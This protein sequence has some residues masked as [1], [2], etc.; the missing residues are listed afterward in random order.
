MDWKI[1]NEFSFEREK[2]NI[3]KIWWLK[4]DKVILG[5]ILFLILFGLFMNFTSSPPIARRIEVEQLF[6]FKKHLIFASISI[7]ILIFF[8]YLRVNHI[9]LIAP[10]LFVIIIITLILTLIFGNEIKGAKRWIS[11]FGFTIQPSE[12]AKVFF[13][14]FNAFLLDKFH[15]RKFYIKYGASG[16]S[17]MILVLLLILQPDFGMSFMMILLWSTQLFLYG[18]PWLAIFMILLCAIAGVISSYI[19]L[20]HVQDR[21]DRFFEIGNNYQVER[22]IDAYINGGF[23]GTGPGGGLVKKHIPDSHS[24]FIFSVIAEEFGIIIS[25]III[26]IFLYL[27][28]VVIKKNN[29]TKGY[30]S[31]L[32][33]SGLIIQFAA[34]III[35]IGVSLEMLPTKGIT[36]PFISYGGSSLIA[37]SISFGI[38]LAL[39]RKRYQTIIKDEELLLSDEQD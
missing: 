27:I 15:D 38:I 11:I 39:T 5:L 29:I 18:L 34:Q 13:I 31:Y 25:S 6:F 10:P 32:T 26:F 7:F 4:I 35:N 37:M 24:D 16:I 2:L 9:K 12:F 20:P 14:I 23:F 21:V 3:I 22:S 19:L 33:I 28:T 30:F 8:S 17:C 1:N 36:L